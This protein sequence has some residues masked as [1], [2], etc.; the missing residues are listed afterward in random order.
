[1]GTAFVAVSGFT[2][3]FLSLDSP[4]QQVYGMPN[5]APEPPIR[6]IEEREAEELRAPPELTKP[7]MVKQ[8]LLN[9]YLNSAA[10]HIKLERFK[11][12]LDCAQQAQ[13]I[14]ECVSVL[15]TTLLFPLSSS[16]VPLTGLLGTL[17][18]PVL[19]CRKN[20]KAAFREAQ[21]RIGL[22]EIQTGKNML[23]EL[24]KKQPDP[25]ISAALQKLASDDKA[26]EAKKAAQFKGMFYKNRQCATGAT[27]AA[28][29]NSAGSNGSATTKGDAKLKIDAAKAIVDSAAESKPVEEQVD[30]KEEAKGA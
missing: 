19:F 4:M 12:A 17:P 3:S 26:R 23:E 13:K 28:G 27:P 21:A 11:R 29:G 30:E 8:A 15:A 16:P 24:Q 20:P 10:I 22:G 2:T 5:R 14:D 18:V 6:A 9:T 25:A 1:M 7:E